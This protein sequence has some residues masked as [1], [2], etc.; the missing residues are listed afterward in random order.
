MSTVLTLRP[1]LEAHRSGALWVPE[2]RTLLIADLHLG[3]SWAQRRRGELGPLVDELSRERVLQVTA[4]LSPERIVF[5][6]DL[7][8]APRPCAEERKWIGSVLTELS[9]RAGLIAVRGNHD[10]AFA[11]EF[12][13][14]PVQ[15]L[16]SWAER[17]FLAMHGDRL[18]EDAGS[19]RILILG[20]WHPSLS[21]SDA[22]GA[23]QRL[24]VFLASDSCIVLPAFSPFARGYDIAAGLPNEL[25]RHFGD[26]EVEA[27]AAT[28]T[29]VVRLGNLRQAL[30]HMYDADSSAPANFRRRRA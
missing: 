12:T 19:G 30:R 29:R 8:H 18:P 17:T 28:R 1:G 10:R 20:H 7:V 27:Y 14:L 23:D 11:R 4:E 13:H 24:P 9:V 25:R 16:E 21:V 26:G 15:I 3:Y 6:G 2:S 22:A 5:L